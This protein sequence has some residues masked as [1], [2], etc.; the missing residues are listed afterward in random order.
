MRIELIV[1]SATLLGT[2][3]TIFLLNA[4]V[5]SRVRGKLSDNMAPLSLEI[6]KSVLFI[7]AGLHIATAD[8]AIRSL[9]SF[10]SP[11]ENT[12]HWLGLTSIFI[13]LSM[14]TLLL[15]L[16]FS[17]MMYTVV[18][19]GR[20]ISFEL[21]S[22]NYGAVIQVSSILIAMT[23]ATKPGLAAVLNYVIPYPKSPLFH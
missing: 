23:I 17:V 21:A 15:N 13:G 5:N 16:W 22:G 19:A 9:S 11:I 4:A 18:S 20:G 2:L 12:S 14:L 10:V 7:I 3:I 8:A 1:L 6:F